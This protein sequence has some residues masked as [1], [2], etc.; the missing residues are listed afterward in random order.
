MPIP[1]PEPK[2]SDLFHVVGFTKAEVKSGVISRSLGI[3]EEGFKTVAALGKYRTCE[4]LVRQMS[5]HAT[6]QE[7]K[8]PININRRLSL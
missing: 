5:G 1:E 8:I 6:Y 7:L 2:A 4:V 3:S